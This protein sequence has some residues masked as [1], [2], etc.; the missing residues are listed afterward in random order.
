MRPTSSESGDRVAEATTC[1]GAFVATAHNMQQKSRTT[2]FFIVD[3]LSDPG[4]ALILLG[5]ALK[6]SGW[7]K[8]GGGTQCDPAQQRKSK[9]AATAG[10]WPVADSRHL[11]WGCSPPDLHLPAVLLVPGEH[12]RA[13]RLPVVVAAVRRLRPVRPAGPHSPSHNAAA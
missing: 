6:S 2:L 5:F 12:L 10:P 3:A 4:E 9:N 13:D 11:E 1:A 7:F 8:A